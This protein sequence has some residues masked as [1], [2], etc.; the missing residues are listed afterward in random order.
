MS[1]L[2]E[3]IVNDDP[4]AWLPRTNDPPVRSTVRVDGP[5]PTVTDVERECEIMHDAYEAAAIKAGWETQRRSR[6]PWSDVPAA[7]KRTMQAA[8]LT[9]VE[10]LGYDTPCR[11]LSVD[12]RVTLTSYHNVTLESEL[13]TP[14]PFATATV[15]K[16]IRPPAATGDGNHYLVTVT[17][18]EALP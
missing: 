5:L 9:L 16:I 3:L 14:T 8:V 11:P 10:H 7:N 1:D 2:P 6:V 17:D 15:T 4:A 13:N 18:V 12:D